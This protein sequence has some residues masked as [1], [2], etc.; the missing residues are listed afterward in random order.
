MLENNINKDFLTIQDLSTLYSLS[1]EMQNK[2]RMQKKIPYIK[3]GK[4]IFYEKERIKEWFL[5]HR[6]N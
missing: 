1:K 5:S 4:K 6:I 3:I 2:Y